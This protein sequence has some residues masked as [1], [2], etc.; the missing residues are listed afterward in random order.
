MGALKILGVGGGGGFK[1][2][3]VTAAQEW[4]CQ[5]VLRVRFSSFNLDPKLSIEK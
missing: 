5:V 2:W 4:Q 1:E 3:D